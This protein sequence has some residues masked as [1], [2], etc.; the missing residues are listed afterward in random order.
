MTPGTPAIDVQH[1]TRRFGSFVAVN[2][3]SFQVG[4]GVYQ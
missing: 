1:L 3:V 2:D 4:R